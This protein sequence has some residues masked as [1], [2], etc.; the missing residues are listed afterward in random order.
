MQKM[1]GFLV[2]DSSTTTEDLVEMRYRAALKHH[3]Y[4]VKMNEHPIFSSPD[5]D[6]R[7]RMSIKGRFERLSIPGIYLNGK[8]DP[9]G[10]EITAY[11]QEDALPNVQF[12]YPEN[13]GHQG[14][15]DQPE[16]FNQVFLEFF[17]DGKVSWETA[18]RAGISTRR[19]PNP[20]TVAVPE[21]IKV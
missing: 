2:D 16:L 15:T 7:A 13:T 10:L 18:Q 5:P 11:P 12:F 3:E 1:V 20:N 17:R 14:Q 4:F 6:T 21:K 9:I 8:N 19:P